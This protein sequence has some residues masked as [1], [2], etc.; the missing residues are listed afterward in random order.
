MFTHFIHC[1]TVYFSIKNIKLVHRFGHFRGFV[2]RLVLPSVFRKGLSGPL[3]PSKAFFVEE[4][5]ITYL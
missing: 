4:F 2:S 1:N 3:I 5:L